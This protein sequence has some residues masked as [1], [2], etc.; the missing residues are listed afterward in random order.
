MNDNFYIKI[1]D[2]MKGVETERTNYFLQSFYKA[3]VNK[4]ISKEKKTELIKRYLEK[5]E[6]IF[7]KK[8]KKYFE[9]NQFII[10]QTIEEENRQFQLAIK[11]SEEEIKLK[12]IQEKEE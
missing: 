1:S 8:E 6:D 2:I 3:A 9:K 10:P 5:T 12:S 11:Q 7:K 4:N